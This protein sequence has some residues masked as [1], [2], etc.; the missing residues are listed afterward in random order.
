MGSIYEFI[1]Y[2]C[3][4]G[5]GHEIFFLWRP[6]LPDPKDD[7]VL[8]LALAAHCDAIVTFNKRDFRGAE[9]FGIRLLTPQEFLKALG[10][11]P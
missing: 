5:R 1:D 11:L 7:M 8:E 3:S 10:E 6:F 4:V 9:Q 2:I